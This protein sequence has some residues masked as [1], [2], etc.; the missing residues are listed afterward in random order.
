MPATGHLLGTPRTVNVV[1]DP[2]PIPR[3]YTVTFHSQAVPGTLAV[4]AGTLSAARLDIV[5]AVVRVGEATVTDSFDVMPL[6]G[7]ELDDREADRLAALAASAL[8]G[9][10]DLAD[11]LRLLHE[12]FPAAI[13]MEPRVEVQTNSALTTGVNVV[14]ADRPGLLYD[15]TSTLTR[16]GLRTRALS[17]LTFSGKAHDTF[18]V[19]DANGEAPTDST[20]LEALSTEL[21]RE[22]T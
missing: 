18:R 21:A 5:S 7:R 20:M 3:M 2:G 10:H 19:V 8:N 11:E 22:C 9:R 6:E 1:I 17:V 13:Q 15:I 14:C 16:F 4:F 12:R